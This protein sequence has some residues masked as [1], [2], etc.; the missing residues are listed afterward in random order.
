MRRYKK[1]PMRGL[2]DAIKTRCYNRNSKSYPYY[3]GREPNP[4]AVC[5]RWR[6]SFENF[7]SDILDEIGPRPD[8]MYLHRTD[9]AG[10]YAP[11]NVQWATPH[12]VNHHCRLLTPETRAKAV[13]SLTGQSFTLERRAKI[14]AARKGQLPTPE[15][16]A[17]ISA[18][19]IGKRLSPSHCAAISTAQRGKIRSPEARANIRAGIRAAA[20]R[21]AA[22]QAGQQI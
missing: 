12:Y 20:V 1:H 5:D 14:A 2:W 21:R 10:D 15:H 16:C 3:G 18:A 8:G 7:A 4:I 17:A 19:K 22:A 13:E 6:Y 11:G 9:N